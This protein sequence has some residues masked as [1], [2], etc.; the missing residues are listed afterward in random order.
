[1]LVGSGKPKTE[2]P[3]HIPVTFQEPDEVGQR[4]VQAHPTVLGP[5]DFHAAAKGLDPAW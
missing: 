4:S 2:I 5:A 1:M 3:A